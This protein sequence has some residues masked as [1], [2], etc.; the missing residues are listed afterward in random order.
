MEADRE[1][2]YG[3]FPLLEEH[4]RLSSV[5]LRNHADGCRCIFRSRT[6]LFGAAAVAIRYNVFSRTPGKLFACLFGAPVL[7]FFANFGASVEA[8]IS[9]KALVAFASFC[10]LLG[11][12][13]KSAKADMGAAVT[14]LP[15]T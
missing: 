10:K 7:S 9:Q 11:I 1:S 8:S 5:N 13:L 6:L 14:S 2:A 4:S 12:A 15:P 3:S